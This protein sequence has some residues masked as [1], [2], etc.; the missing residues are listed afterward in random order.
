MKRD[1][2]IIVKLTKEEKN[3]IVGNAKKEGLTLSSYV[4]YYLIKGGK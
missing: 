2:A 4:R 3:K 1:E